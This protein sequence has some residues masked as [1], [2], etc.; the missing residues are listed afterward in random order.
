MPDT[1]ETLLQK[2]NAAIA[3]SNLDETIKICTQIINHSDT[4]NP[5]KAIAYFSRGNAYHDKGE[6]DHAIQDFDKVIEL[7]PDDAEA[8]YNRGNAYHGKDKYDCAIQDYDKA[9]ELEPDYAKAYGNRGNAYHGKGEYDHAIQDFDKV[10]EINPD[11]TKAYSNRGSTYNAIGKHGR[12]IQDCD[13]AIELNPDYA[14]A[15]GNRG[16]AYHGKGEHDRAIQDY[17]KAIELN[18]DDAKAYGNRGNAYHGKGEHDRAIQDYDKAIELEPDYAGAYDNRGI[19]YYDKGD[20]DRAIQDYDKAIELKPDDAEAYSNR[21]IA[22]SD[23]GEHGRAI[24]DYDKAI[25]LKPSLTDAIHNRGV[26]M[27][28]KLAGETQKKVSDKYEKQLKE[29]QEGFESKLG[30]AESELKEQQKTFESTLKEKLEKRMSL[31][32][33][34]KEREE[35]YRERLEGKSKNSEGHSV[36]R[37]ISFSVYASLVFF[38][39]GLFILIFAKSPCKLPYTESIF[40]IITFGQEFNCS[41]VTNYILLPY[42]GLYF[43]LAG[44]LILFPLLKEL[45]QI[46]DEGLR[47]NLSKGFMR[48]FVVAC[49]VYSIVVGLYISSSDS[50]S[51]SGAVPFVFV[52]TLILSPLAWNLRTL[53]QE[54]RE[55]SILREDAHTNYVLIHYMTE[56]YSNVSDEIYG[57]LLKQFFEHHDKR[58]SA[59]TIADLDR[60]V[61]KSDSDGIVQN[62]MG[63]ATK[64]EKQVKLPPTESS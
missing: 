44:I 45:R 6:Y 47:K 62:I 26:A 63:Y 64:A 51:F 55:A 46:E 36:K 34:Y 52:G 49:I 16:N 57:E 58:S 41:R 19:A 8:Y 13:K 9:I 18:P 30:E 39:I 14:E 7:N 29:Q 15:Y 28:L 37:T 17:D 4:G 38:V 20:N 33:Y 11:D 2:A 12:A 3:R 35:E 48:F 43:I 50:L 40:T 61:K 60:P 24:Q 53:R 5:Q 27:A 42:A 21:G 54:I 22:Y 1:L 32:D 56:R 23:K 59:Q 25:E 31:L 10:I